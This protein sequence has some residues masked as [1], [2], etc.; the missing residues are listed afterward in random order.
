MVNRIA[1]FIDAARPFEEVNVFS[2][3]VAGGGVNFEDSQHLGIARVEVASF[4]GGGGFGVGDVGIIDRTLNPG[5]QIPAVGIEG[6]PFK[7]P[8]RPSLGVDGG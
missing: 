3:G 7:S 5:K 6:H 8:I 2:R 4:P 1:N